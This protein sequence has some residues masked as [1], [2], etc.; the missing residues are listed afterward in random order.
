[1]SRVSS[2]TCKQLGSFMDGQPGV[3]DIPSQKTISDS[4]KECLFGLCSSS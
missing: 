4:Y 1:M 3:L 2:Q